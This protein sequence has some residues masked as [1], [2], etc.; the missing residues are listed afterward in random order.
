M[1]REQ[2]NLFFQFI[3]QRYEDE[4]MKL[5]QAISIYSR[6]GGLVAPV[7]C[8]A[9]CCL[10]PGIAGPPRTPF[11]SFMADHRGLR[12]SPRGTFG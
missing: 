10:P 12:K 11:R 3:A 8:G 6:V 9:G 2:A 4:Q 7:R 1:T 5:P